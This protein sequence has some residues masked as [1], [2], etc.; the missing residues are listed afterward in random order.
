MNKIQ[1][2]AKDMFNE[3]VQNNGTTPGIINCR[4]EY[5]DDKTNFD[6]FICIEYK[7]KKKFSDKDKLIFFYCEGIHEFVDLCSKNNG[8]DFYVT[9]IYGMQGRII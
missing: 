7:N 5:K 4:V 2:K 3:Y 6:A 9:E 8:E 1:R